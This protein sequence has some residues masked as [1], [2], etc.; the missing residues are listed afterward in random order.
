MYMYRQ[1]GKN[2]VAERPFQEKKSTF[3]T[4]WWMCMKLVRGWALIVF[5]RNLSWSLFMFYV[6]C[7]NISVIYMYMYVTAQRKLDMKQVDNIFF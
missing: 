7:N 3:N 2:P 1:I 6:T 5:D 4:V